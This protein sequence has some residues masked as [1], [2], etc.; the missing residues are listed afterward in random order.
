MKRVYH[1][2]KCAGGE[3]SVGHEIHGDEVG[4]ALEEEFTV[5]AVRESLVGAGVGAEE[6]RMFSSSSSPREV[7]P[8][9]NGHIT[10]VKVNNMVSGEVS[11][12]KLNGHINV[13]FFFFFLYFCIFVF[14]YFC[15]C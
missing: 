7:F 15:C 1:S 13:F 9:R 11:D 4:D 10:L 5:R 2:W 8:V 14:L 6:S 12:L 3:K